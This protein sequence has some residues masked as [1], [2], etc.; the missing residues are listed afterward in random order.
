MDGGY[1]GSNKMKGPTVARSRAD[2]KSKSVARA[3]HENIN[4]RL[5]IFRILDDIFRGNPGNAVTEENKFGTCDKKHQ[6]SFAAVAVIVQLGF[7]LDG[8]LYG[9]DYNVKYD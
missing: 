5:K 1:N 6:W 8:G 2:R 4:G 7:E 3:R 9:I